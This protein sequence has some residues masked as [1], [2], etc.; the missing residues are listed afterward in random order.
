MN[1]CKI[2][3]TGTTTNSSLKKFASSKPVIKAVT[4]LGKN[5]PM[6]TILSVVSKDLVGALILFC[7]TKNNKRIP[8]K[9]RNYLASYELTSGSY[10]VLFPLTAGY[11]LTTETFKHK[12]AKMLFKDYYVAPK[13]LE[14]AEAALKTGVAKK[15]KEV[16]LG[17]LKN[18]MRVFEKCNK[19]LSSLVAVIFT[20]IISKRI[21]CP[22]VGGPMA[23][24]FNKKFLEGK[25]K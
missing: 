8:E 19:G 14:D 11:F 17:K 2:Q 7:Q 6:I 16:E 3:S 13:T 5:I 12:T 21:I 25:D 4:G 10:N 23:T 1:I 24:V 20:A 22:F 9:K 15:V 18:K